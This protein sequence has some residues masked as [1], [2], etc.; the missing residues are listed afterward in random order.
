MAGH[1]A[2][3][4]AVGGPIAALRDG[5]LVTFDIEGRRLDVDLDD[6]A[7]ADRLAGWSPPAPRYPSG[8]MGRYAALV[9]SAARGAI[10]DPRGVGEGLTRLV[11]SATT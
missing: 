10:T 9:S 8:V 5:D 6:V 4:A 11:G 1:V 2:P 7:L 3:E